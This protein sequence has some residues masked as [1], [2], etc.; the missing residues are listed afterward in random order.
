M[1]N[2]HAFLKFKCEHIIGSIQKGQKMRQDH[3]KITD[4][5]VLVY[6]TVRISEEENLHNV[7]HENITNY[8]TKGKFNL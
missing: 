5:A 3:V 7:L 2:R 8:L 1:I 6:I 4:L